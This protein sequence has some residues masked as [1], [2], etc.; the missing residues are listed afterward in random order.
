[1]DRLT[2][3]AIFVKAADLGS[4]AAVAEA[5]GLSA[6]MVGKHVQFLEARLGVRLLNRTTRRQS[7]TD[8]G[9]AYYDRCR[10]I[11]N[12]AEAAEALASEHLNRPHGTLRVA[13]PALLGRMCV[14]PLLL[15]L[16]RR[17]PT[18][19]LDLSLDDQ[20]IDLVACGFDLAVRTG[21]TAERPGLAM[22]RLGGHRM[23]VCGSPDYLS[24]RG[25]PKTLDDLPDHT[26]VM[27][28]RPGWEHSWL[29]RNGAGDVIEVAPSHRLRFNDM[30]SVADAAASG[31][32]LAWL[33]AWLARPHLAAGTLIEVLRDQPCFTFENYAVWPR[34]AHPPLRVRL[35]ID[36]LAAGLPEKLA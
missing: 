36:L 26:A 27:Y 22:R 29:F 16:G 15:D 12:E 7:I 11:L 28:A 23:I 2:S 13:A 8:F 6:T 5:T 35:A 20:L 17:H 18:I 3:M 19:S 21:A 9:R 33:P 34:A 25:A 32:G 10:V 4:F 14:A 31:A 30:A 1:M 24:A